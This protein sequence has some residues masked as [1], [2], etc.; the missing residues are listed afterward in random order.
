MTNHKIWKKNGISIEGIN[1]MTLY[2]LCDLDF[3]IEL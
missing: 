3:K 2:H 1:L